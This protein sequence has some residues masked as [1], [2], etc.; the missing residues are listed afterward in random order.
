MAVFQNAPA[1]ML[2]LTNVGMFGRKDEGTRRDGAADST[3][4]FRSGQRDHVATEHEFRA[5]S[6]GIASKM[7]FRRRSARIARRARARAGKGEEEQPTAIVSLS[8]VQNAKIHVEME[9]GVANK[10]CRE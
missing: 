6:F 8:Q 4:N 10:H 3:Q 1:A 9:K 5:L 2:A 7:L